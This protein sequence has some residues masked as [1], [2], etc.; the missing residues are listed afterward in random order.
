MNKKLLF[1]PFLLLLLACGST[2]NTQNQ[3]KL[4]FLDE[5]VVPADARFQDTPVGGLSGI[6]YENGQYYLVC[7]Q[8][9]NPRF[10]TAEIKLNKSSID[11]IIFKDMVKIDR[12]KGFPEKNVL[13]LEAIRFDP[14]ENELVITSEGSIENNVN[15]GVYEITPEGEFISKFE[16]PDY[17]KVN[18]EQK[19]RNNGVFEGLSPGI[20]HKGYWVST[21]L[22]LEKDGP[23][24]KFYPTNSPARIT[25]FDSESLQPTKQFAVKLGRIHKFPINYFAVN[26]I[27]DVLE[28]KKDHFLVLERAYSAGY[29]S[30]GNTVRIYDVDAS[31]ATNILNSENLRKADYEPAKKR[32]VFDFKSV[33]KELTDKIIDNIEG[34]TFGP[35]LPNGKS[36]LVLVSDNNFNSYGEQLNQF[37]LLQIDL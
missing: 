5:Y 11:S 26:G 7:D 16:L 29:G 2:K 34:M 30:H 1:L 25:Y 22:P 35:K 37:I 13:D 33:K 17:F 10:Y 28:Y 27:T 3:V 31:A 36:T 32:L 24:P 23:N 20:E 8:S 19:P 18:G 15:P 9:S 14:A 6:D 4:S 21:E 12:S